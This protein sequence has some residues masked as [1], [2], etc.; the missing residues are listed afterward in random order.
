[1]ALFAVAAGLSYKMFRDI[2]QNEILFFTSLWDVYAFDMVW[3]RVAVGIV[4]FITWPLMLRLTIHWMCSETKPPAAQTTWTGLSL[5]LLFYVGTFLPP[6][7]IPLALILPAAIA[8]AVILGAFRLGFGR[9]LTVWLIHLVLVF[10]SGV[11]VFSGVE[12]YQSGEFFNPVTETTALLRFAS[13]PEAPGE[14]TISSD[15][16]PLDVLLQWSPTGSAWLDRRAGQTVFTVYMQP[17]ARVQVEMIA[18]NTNKR[19]LS[20]SVEETGWTASYGI[21]AG[22]P[23]LLTVTGPEEVSCHLTVTGILPVE[24]LQASA[25]ES[26]A[27]PV[28][29]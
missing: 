13:T 1:M 16:L 28:T 2:D 8:L 24:L 12:T 9:S 25:V 21:D 18:L 4:A 29:E 14:N 20:E 6:N 7:L 10:F 15:Q 17:S 5:G 3:S 23:Y 19:Y 11:L 26:P 27:L 22:K